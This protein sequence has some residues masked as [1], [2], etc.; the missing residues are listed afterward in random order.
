M[1]EVKGKRHRCVT[2]NIT[3]DPKAYFGRTTKEQW[4]QHVRSFATVAK[5]PPPIEP[6]QVSMM[7]WLQLSGM[8]EDDLG[9]I[10][11]YMKTV[12]PIAKDVNPFPDA[13]KGEPVAAAP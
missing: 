5:N 9:A 13:P 8:T 6:W 10:Y 4:I 7:P 11:D 2:A 12:R 3:P 1:P